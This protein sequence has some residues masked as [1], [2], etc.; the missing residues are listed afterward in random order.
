MKFNNLSNH[1]PERRRKFVVAFVFLLTPLAA[2]GV[3]YLLIPFITSS[4]IS[5]LTTKEII[6]SL[7]ITI[8][9]VGMALKYVDY[10][11]ANQYLSERQIILGTDTS[12]NYTI[13]TCLVEN[14]GRNRIVPQNVYLFVDEGIEKNKRIEFPFCLKHEEGENDC[15]LGKKCKSGGINSFPLDLVPDDFKSVFHRSFKMQNLSAEAIMFIDPG[16]KF[17]EDIVL[18]LNPGIYRATAVWTAVKSDCIC[19]T[20]QFVV[21][22]SGTEVG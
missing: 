15:V 14:M 12:S 22:Q 2:W 6:A 8:T 4:D 13:I 3:I 21:P 10:V 9:I 1:P 17:S 16:E 19:A 18:N 20:K 5:S 7:A 11:L